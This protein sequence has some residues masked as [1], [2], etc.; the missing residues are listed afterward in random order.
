MIEKILK[1][2]ANF[3][4]GIAFLKMCAFPKTLLA[5]KAKAYAISAGHEKLVETRMF[6]RRKHLKWV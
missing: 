5:Q 6:M 4:S 2:S 3:A 1:F